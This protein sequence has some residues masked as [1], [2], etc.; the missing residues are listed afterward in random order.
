MEIDSNIQGIFPLATHADTNSAVHAQSPI[1]L[2]TDA[3]LAESPPSVGN[4]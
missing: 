2:L 4:G 1:T 3:T